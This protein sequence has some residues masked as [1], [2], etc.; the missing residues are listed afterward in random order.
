MR[1]RLESTRR[2]SASKRRKRGTMLVSIQRQRSSKRVI[3]GHML[4]EH[5][6]RALVQPN[7]DLL[8]SS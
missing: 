4:L 1:R 6:Q 5:E 2:A 8:S 3:L 7:L